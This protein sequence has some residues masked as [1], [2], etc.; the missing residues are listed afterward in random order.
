MIWWIPSTQCF[1]R[2]EPSIFLNLNLLTKVAE[3]RENQNLLLLQMFSLNI[4]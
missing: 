3:V 1:D 2:E 4:I